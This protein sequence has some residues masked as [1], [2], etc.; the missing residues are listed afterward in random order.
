M[1]KDWGKISIFQPYI[2]IGQPV[3][4]FTDLIGYHDFY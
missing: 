2:I 3:I 4:R 1:K